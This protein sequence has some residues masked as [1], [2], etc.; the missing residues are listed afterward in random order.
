M[1]TP[2]RVSVP[3]HPFKVQVEKAGRWV[4]LD[5]ATAVTEAQAQAAIKALATKGEHGRMVVR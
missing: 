5:W 4:T 3:V 2:E 1:T